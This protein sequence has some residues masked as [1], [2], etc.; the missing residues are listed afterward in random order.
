MF[1]K[2]LH[3]T[4]LKSEVL[5][6]ADPRQT[7]PFQ[8]TLDRDAVPMKKTDRLGGGAASMKADL[9]LITARSVAAGR[10]GTGVDLGRNAAVDTVRGVRSGPGVGRAGSGLAGEHHNEG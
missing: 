3:I 9:S 10:L 8:T 2:V 4:T 6:A 5:R 1:A 7:A